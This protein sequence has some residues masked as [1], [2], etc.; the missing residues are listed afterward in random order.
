VRAQGREPSQ[1]EV[2]QLAYWRMKPVLGQITQPRQAAAPVPQTPPK[3]APT[4]AQVR[5][6]KQRQHMRQGRAAGVPQTA[7]S[8]AGGLGEVER[9]LRKQNPLLSIGQE[10]AQS[11]YADG[12]IG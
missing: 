11:L 3:P 6:E 10:F 2:F 12:G 1:E 7:G 4:P 9:P 5:D 8:T